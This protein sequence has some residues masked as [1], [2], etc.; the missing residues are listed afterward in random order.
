M[1]PPRLPSKLCLHRHRMKAIMRRPH[2][3]IPLPIPIHQRTSPHRIILPSIQAPTPHILTTPSLL[4]HLAL[5]LLLSIPNTLT[6]PQ[7][8]H[9]SPMTHMIH[10]YI[11]D[12]PVPIRRDPRQQHPRPRLM[13]CI[14]LPP[15]VLT[16]VINVPF[17]LIAR[18]I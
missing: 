2:R 15:S 7:S 8:C 3:S 14:P 9:P 13:Q 10:L 12:M 18:T 16:R 11:L 1:P 5:N 6:P 17:R 4:Q